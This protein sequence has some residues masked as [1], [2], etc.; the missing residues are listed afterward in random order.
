MIVVHVTYLTSLSTDPYLLGKEVTI[1]MTELQS[2]D[3]LKSKFCIVLET[4][5][6]GWR[7]KRQAYR[8]TKNS[9]GKYSFKLIFTSN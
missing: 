8:I 2:A 3:L 6:V 7:K 4:T 9:I 1:T 5:C